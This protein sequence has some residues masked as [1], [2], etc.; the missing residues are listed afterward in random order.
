MSDRLKLGRR[1]LGSRV[2][3]V[4]GAALLV[5]G[6]L[7]LWG[8]AVLFD[9][10]GFAE[11]AT[12]ALENEDV[13]TV[14]AD[15]LTDQIIAQSSA[16]L[17]TV[18][19]LIQAAVSQAVASRPFHSIFRRAIRETHSSI[20]GEDDALV[21]RLVDFMIVISAS[22]E[23]LDPELAARLPE[24]RT[25]L[26]EL[27]RR[28]FAAEFIAAAHDVRFL[29]WL[30]PLLGLVA[31]G[32]SVWMATDRN[33]AWMRLGIASSV[34]GSTLLAGLFVGRA[35]LTAP[36]ADPVE[37]GAVA[38]LWDAFSQG[39]RFW[40]LGLIVVGLGLAAAATSVVRQIDVL[41]GLERVRAAI[42][43]VPS[44]RWGRMARAAAIIAVGAAVVARPGQTAVALLWLLGLYALYYGF[45]ELVKAF[46]I[47]VVAGAE[48]Q[49]VRR[50]FL[51]AFGSRAV[52]YT[53][54]VGILLVAYVVV[55]TLVGRPPTEERLLALPTDIEACNGSPLLC[56]RRLD[57]VVFS[58]THNSMSAAAER[59]WLFAS[60]GGGVRD[61]LE[62]GIRGFL[63]DAYFGLSVA[64][65]V[66]SDLMHGADR[67]ALVEQ[68]GE[69]FVAARDR[70]AASL[71]LTDPDVQRTVYLCHVFCELGATPMSETLAVFREFLQSHPHEVIVVFV[72]DHIPAA[73]VAAVFEEAGLE[74]YAYTYRPGTPWPTLREMIEA[75]RRLLVMAENDGSG[76]DWYHPGFEFTQE[77]PYSFGSPAE[78]SCEPNRGRPDSRLFLLNHWIE[79]VMPS[80]ADAEAVNRYEVL[81]RR[82]LLCESRRGL[83]PNLLA[84]NFYSLGD[85]LR[86]ADTLN[87]VPLVD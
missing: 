69:E 59:G 86:V 30:L 29:G 79:G 28:D 67:E 65:G 77:T 25:N 41:R 66:R 6:L 33:A 7:T 18:R 47:G 68:Y 76:P 51:S 53:A 2:F 31:F 5:P 75:N 10:D 61:Q 20:F 15:Q 24:V 70:V 8:R 34:V 11:R 52:L 85:V 12:A 63:I 72:E 3:A 56:D 46:G 26:I 21:L 4:V 49:T 36:V 43:W 27:R 22:L 84:V 57:E 40:S 73:D 35:L 39:L 23:S 87:G 62:Y 13:R 14:V 55:A 44:T 82:A 48:S 58:S 19:P 50:G 78:F 1:S 45:V 16:E 60:H 9:A 54:T 71:G 17:I 42:L 83:V 64:G 80:P 32:L 38:G 74:P 37:A 81:L